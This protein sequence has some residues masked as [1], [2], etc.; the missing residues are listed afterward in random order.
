MDHYGAD[1][2]RFGVLSCAAAGNDLL[3]EEKLCENGRNFTNKLYNAYMLIDS[4][5]TDSSE[6]AP[7]DQAAMQWFEARLE[8]LTSYVDKAITEFRLSEALMELYKATW[9][10][11]CSWYLEFVKRSKGQSYPAAVK[12]KSIEF[13]NQLLCPASFIPFITEELWQNL[14]ERKKVKVF[15]SVLL[16]QVN[17]G[18][19][20][21]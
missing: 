15:G 2:V 20:L 13:F 3:F 9:T 17:Q 14:E 5:S 10:D 19:D 1:G 6:L 18:F 11:F 7:E 12:E 8:Q 16:Q 21:A 4:W